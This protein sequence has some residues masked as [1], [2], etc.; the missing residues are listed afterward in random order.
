MN[1]NTFLLCNT[2]VMIHCVSHI[3][4]FSS[5]SSKSGDL[6]HNPHQ[7][8]LTTGL[9]CG[10]A[11][12]QTPQR[13]GPGPRNSQRSWD[14]SYKE[15][16]SLQYAAAVVWWTEPVTD[17]ANLKLNQQ[18]KWQTNGRMVCTESCVSRC[19]RT[20]IAS[21]LV[22]AVQA[23]ANENAMTLPMA[24]SQAQPPRSPP[25]PPPPPPLHIPRVCDC[26]CF[27]FAGSEA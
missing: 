8:N 3:P 5:F 11:G 12:G 26:N 23:N 2:G 21:L 20:S 6:A 10:T 22:V 4:S 18:S 19:F 16:C 17:R 14:L 9:T 25:S 13:D 7:V 27:H 24:A 1:K 15:T